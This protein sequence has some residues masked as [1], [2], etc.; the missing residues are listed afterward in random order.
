MVRLRALIYDIS[1]GFL[2]LGGL[3]K[4]DSPEPDLK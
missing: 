3:T 1:D 2:G 4:S